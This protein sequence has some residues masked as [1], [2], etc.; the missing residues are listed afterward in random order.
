MWRPGDVQ[1]RHLF[2]RIPGVYPANTWQIPGSPPSH[3]PTKSARAAHVARGGLSAAARFASDFIGIGT[4]GWRPA[5][6]ASC[7][8]MYIYREPSSIN[9]WRCWKVISTSEVFVSIVAACALMRAAPGPILTFVWAYTRRIPGEYLA[10]TWE[11]AQPPT[12]HQIR[13]DSA[14]RPWRA[15]GSFAFC[16]RFQWY[17]DPRVA[18]R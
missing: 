10:D 11:P 6:W 3:Q 8:Y 9:A 7:P 12:A 2:G 1:F 4:P 15:F 17:W 16:Q 18:A 14:R 5:H 13:Q